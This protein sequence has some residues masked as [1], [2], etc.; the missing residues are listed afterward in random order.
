MAEGLATCLVSGEAHT[1][2]SEIGS[3]PRNPSPPIRFGGRTVAA[4]YKS[5]PTVCHCG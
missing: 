2:R 3:A 1:G 5:R 4:N